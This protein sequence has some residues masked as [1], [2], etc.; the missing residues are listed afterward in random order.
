MVYYKGVLKFNISSVRAGFETYTKFV[1]LLPE[2]KLLTL[3]C[4]IIII[5]IIM[6]EAVLIISN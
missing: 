4:T 5:P 2:K 1:A 3:R 6:L